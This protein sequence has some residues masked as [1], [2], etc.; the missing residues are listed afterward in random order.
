[1]LHFTSTPHT[2]GRGSSYPGI[3]AEQEGEHEYLE[4]SGRLGRIRDHVLSVMG[5]GVVER[6][7][8]E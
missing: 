1:L 5:S 4:L 2:S 7:T 6:G 8:A 3:A